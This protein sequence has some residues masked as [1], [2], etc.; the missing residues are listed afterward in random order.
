MLKYILKRLLISLVVLFGVSIIIYSL[1]RMMPN[2]YIDI[3]YAQQIQNGTITP[4]QVQKFKE[5]YG[6]GDDSFEGV[7]KGYFKWLGNLCQGNLGT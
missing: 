5:L 7:I 4:E 2:D 6:L 1:V 3:K